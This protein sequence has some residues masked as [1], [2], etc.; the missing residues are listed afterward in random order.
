[1]PYNW[2]ELTYRRPNPKILPG[3]GSPF[4]SGL[5]RYRSGLKACGFSYTFSSMVIALQNMRNKGLIRLVPS[6]TVRIHLPGIWDDHGSL[7]NSHSA[8]N[9]V[10]HHTMRDTCNCQS[11]STLRNEE[12]K[13]Y[14]VARM[15]ATL[16]AFVL[17]T[18]K[19]I[20]LEIWYQPHWF[21]HDTFDIWEG[22]S[23]VKFRESSVP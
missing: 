6:W 15:V 10:F 4:P 21:L 5:G 20:L 19:W 2:S 3:N 1:M 8:V 18:W 9:I 7:W 22:I 14:R 11:E 23:V 16:E 13:S 17:V 12:D